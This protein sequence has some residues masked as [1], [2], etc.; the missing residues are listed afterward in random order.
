VQT[1]A[2]QICGTSGRTD[3]SEVQQVVPCRLLEGVRRFLRETELRGRESDDARE[4][5]EGR[6][7]ERR[8]RS[9][10]LRPPTDDGMARRSDREEGLVQSRPLAVAFTGSNDRATVT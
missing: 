6:H 4:E 9:G 2:L 7:R 1:C 5:P 8:D 10:L 3:R